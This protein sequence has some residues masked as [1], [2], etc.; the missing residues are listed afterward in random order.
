MIH[1]FDNNLLELNY[2]D[3][4]EDF[5]QNINSVSPLIEIIKQYGSKLTKEDQAFCME[6]V[7][8]GLTIKNKLD[9]SENDM[10]FKFQSAGIEQYLQG[11]N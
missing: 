2:T 3:I 8:W 1:W 4:D 5:Y 10:A 11:N 9:R 6:I 7:L